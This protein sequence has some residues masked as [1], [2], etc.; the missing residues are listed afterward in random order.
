MRRRVLRGHQGR[1]PSSGLRLRLRQR[2]GGGKGHRT[3][4]TRWH[5]DAGGSVRHV[6][7]V[8]HVSPPG[9]CAVGIGENAPRFAARLRR[10]VPHPF[11]DFHGVRSHREE[12]PAGMDQHG[13]QD[14]A[15]C[16][17]HVRH[18][19]GDG[20]F[21]GCRED[22]KR[23]RRVQ[24]FHAAPAPD[25]EHVSHPPID[26][27]GRAASSE[28]PGQTRAICSRGRDEGH[29]VLRVRGGILHRTRH[30]QP[31]RHAAE[32]F[33]HMRHRSIEREI[34]SADPHPVGGATQHAGS[35]KDLHAV[36][37]G[38]KPQRL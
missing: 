10:R 12:V 2:D 13:R 26:A 11:P 28:Q 31:G 9:P 5:R 38:R 37:H 32:E 24:L 34:G 27:A 14:G 30:G 7:I 6:Q 21:G 15:R 25:L 33:G 4:D 35:D 1:V 36:A 23:Y 19:E 17:R 16:Q 8:E 20:R 29:G 18:L 3:C 22:Q